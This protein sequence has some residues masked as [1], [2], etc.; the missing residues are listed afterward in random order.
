MYSGIDVRYLK[1]YNCNM[2]NRRIL[3]DN[4]HIIK[5]VPEMSKKY[6]KGSLYIHPKRGYHF[7][8]QD[9]DGIGVIKMDWQNLHKDSKNRIIKDVNKANKKHK[10][11]KE[12]GLYYSKNVR[13]IVYQKTQRRNS[14]VHTLIRNRF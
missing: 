7:Y 10:P 9:S 2:L 14:L 4:K 3:A 13:L 12:I 6:Y 1:E 8:R 5:T 11:M